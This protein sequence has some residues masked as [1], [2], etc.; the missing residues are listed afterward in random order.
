M[1]TPA[2]LGFG[3]FVPEKTKNVTRITNRRPR[4]CKIIF[5]KANSEGVESWP[6]VATGTRPY[7]LRKVVNQLVVIKKGLVQQK[8]GDGGS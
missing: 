7:M 4:Q 6:P 8:G 5:K 3:K 1:P 2:E